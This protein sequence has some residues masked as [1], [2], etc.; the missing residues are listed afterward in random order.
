MTTKPR[1][2]IESI[3]Y[4]DRTKVKGTYFHQ[5]PLDL[6]FRTLNGRLQQEFQA[7]VRLV[8]EPDNPYDKHAVSVRWKDSVIG[9]LPAELCESYAQ[10][11]RVAAS[12]YDA[13]TTA[14]VWATDDWDGERKY[15]VW[16]TLPSPEL[17]LPLNE[18]PAD[19][20]ALLP[21]GGKVQVTKESDHSDYLT[22]F[23]PPEGEGQILVSL[24]CF[25]AGKTKKWTG[26]EVRLDGE[27]I[28]E[29]TK[30]SSE[31]FAPAI[32]HFNN[33]GLDLYCRAIIQGSSV[34]AEVVLCGTK[35]YEL[36]ESFL[37]AKDTK[38]LNKLVDFQPDASD[39]P[40]VNR[41]DPK[42]S[43][44]RRNRLQNANTRT[45]AEQTAAYTSA[46]VAPSTWLPDDSPDTPAERDA[47]IKPDDST[48]GCI[49][50]GAILFVLLLIMI[51]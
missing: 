12:G 15:H 1:Y 16:V 6:M 8:P 22:D 7:E 18:P 46:K 2:P 40:S 29:L 21:V 25:E 32:E 19:G 28:G 9:Y 35:A 36:P 37:E 33:R 48:L 49:G 34:A 51:L 5:K 42:S 23:V 17:L 11:R 13:S 44:E 50:C 47:S 31:K 24:H 30:V 43:N 10:L 14:G 26:V 45:L 3:T 20:F 39:Y 27:R 41:Y 4:H 38:P